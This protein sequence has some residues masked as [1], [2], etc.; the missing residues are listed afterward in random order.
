MELAKLDHCLTEDVAAFNT[1]CRDSGVAAIIAKPPP[2]VADSGLP[3]D[4]RS[5]TKP[6]TRE[7]VGRAALALGGSVG[8]VPATQSTVRPPQGDGAQ[9]RP[10]PKRLLAAASCV[11]RRAPSASRARAYAP[12]MV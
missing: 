6:R 9:P 1:L 5:R 4:L 11:P 2:S 8:P 10:G 7:A 12:G 3:V